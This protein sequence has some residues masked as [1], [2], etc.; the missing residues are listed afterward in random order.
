MRPDFVQLQSSP[1]ECQVV[2]SQAKSW[3]TLLPFHPTVT[4][5]P[6]YPLK[7]KQ[8]RQLSQLQTSG[9]DFC[10]IAVF[11]SHSWCVCSL[12]LDSTFRKIWGRWDFL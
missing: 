1:G 7:K 2:G 11:S 5:I 12:L 4:K 8:I 6:Y 3:A 9:P 10:L